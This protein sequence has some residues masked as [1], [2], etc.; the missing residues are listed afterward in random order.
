MQACSELCKF[1]IPRDENEGGQNDIL[2]E[3]EHCEGSSWW[4]RSFKLQ[5]RMRDSSGTSVGKD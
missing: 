5:K 1:S 2:V 4:T 3:S